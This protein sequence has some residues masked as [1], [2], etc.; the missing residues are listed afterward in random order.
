MMR[1]GK[2]EDEVEE[3]Q[4][5]SLLLPGKR[6]M[7]DR[8]GASERAWCTAVVCIS[9]LAYTTLRKSERVCIYSSLAGYTLARY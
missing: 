1:D 6:S 9:L 5:R 4:Q 2:E 7:L 8:Y 3:Q